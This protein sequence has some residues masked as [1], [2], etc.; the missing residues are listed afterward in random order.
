MSEWKVAMLFA[1]PFM[2]RGAKLRTW[3]A[4]MGAS[5]AALLFPPMAVSAYIAIDTIAG[6]I[7]L[8]K[9]AGEVQRAIGRVFILMVLFHLGYL[10]SQAFFGEVPGAASFYHNANV[11]AGWVQFAF[12]LG[13]GLWDAGLAW[14]RF[15]NRRRNV[16]SEAFAK[17]AE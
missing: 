11:A 6:V 15:A 13:W 14:A 4:L 2:G 3:I 1:L 12:L 5:A 9:P 10:T 17:A 7:V 8:A 16:R